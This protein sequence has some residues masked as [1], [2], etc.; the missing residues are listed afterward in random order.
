MYGKMY[1]NEAFMSLLE[2][3]ETIAKDEGITKA[4]LAYRWVN[5]HS[6]LTP[7]YG[8]ALIFGASS[9]EQLEQTCGYVQKGP[10]SESAAKKIDDLWPTV[11]DQS[12]MDNFQAAFAS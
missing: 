10:L 7:K 1:N 12:I 6:A 4:E 9:L 5:H 2:K 8:D 3:W 11:K